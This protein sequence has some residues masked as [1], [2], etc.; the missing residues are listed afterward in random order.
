LTSLFATFVVQLVAYRWGT[1][2]LAKRGI[3]YESEM[4]HRPEG[5]NGIDNT[6]GGHDVGTGMPVNGSNPNGAAEAGRIQSEKLESKETLVGEG[7][8][9][10]SEETPAAAQILG[11]AILEFG[12]VFHSVCYLIFTDERSLSG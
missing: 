10:A 12:V 7:Y 3:A 1:N 6:H 5:Y 8:K 11:V 9:D 4:S 2:Y